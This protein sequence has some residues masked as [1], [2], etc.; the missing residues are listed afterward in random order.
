M[1]T[2]LPALQYTTNSLAVDD[3][4]VAHFAGWAQQPGSRI[5][6]P[7]ETVLLRREGGSFVP[8]QVPEVGFAL[9]LL[10]DGDGTHHLWGLNGDEPEHFFGTPGG[11]W[12]SEPWIVPA[13]SWKGQVGLT[14]DGATVSYGIQS[15]DPYGYQLYV[16]VDGQTKVLGSEMT[17]QSLVDDYQG[18]GGPVPAEPN[19]FPRYGAVVNGEEGLRVSWAGNT[20]WGETVVADTAPSQYVCPYGSPAPCPVTCVEQ[21]SGVDQHWGGIAHAPVSVELP[22]DA[23]PVRWTRR[24][25]LHVTLASLNVNI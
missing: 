6:G 16:Y 8:Q 21:G 7:G 13:D 1:L 3:D 11:G 19:L 22:R 23:G 4:G 25:N 18:F 17:Q 14:A 15:K 12:Q 9:P 24:P 20:G 10:I 5:N 2:D